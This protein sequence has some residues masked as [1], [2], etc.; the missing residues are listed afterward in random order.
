MEGWEKRGCPNLQVEWAQPCASV[1]VGVIGCLVCQLALTVQI[2]VLHQLLDFTQS[3]ATGYFIMQ[4]DDSL[5]VLDAQDVKTSRC[6]SSLHP[7]VI[8]YHSNM[9]GNGTQIL[10]AMLDST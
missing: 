1:N 9:Q 3:E 8:F 6:A 7:H 4:D 2:T 10:K 5:V